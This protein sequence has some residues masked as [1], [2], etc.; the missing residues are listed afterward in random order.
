M[1]EKSSEELE[2]ELRLINAQVELALL[3]K[4]LGPKKAHTPKKRVIYS[5]VLEAVKIPNSMTGESLPKR[6]EVDIM[7][8]EGQNNQIRFKTTREES[9]WFELDE[10]IV[11]WTNN[12]NETWYY[13]DE[14]TPLNVPK[15]VPFK[16]ISP[17]PEHYRINQQNM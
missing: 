6:I 2:L 14:F 1:R 10:D 16:C 17:K 8:R 3:K 11:A 7:I 5:R 9:P 4:Q 15:G 12:Q 13:A